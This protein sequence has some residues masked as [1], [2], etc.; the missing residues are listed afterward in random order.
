MTKQDNEYGNYDVITGNFSNMRRHAECKQ[1]RQALASLGLI[2]VG[3][4]EDAPSLSAFEQVARGRMKGPS[5][6]RHGEAGVGGRKKVTHMVQCLGDAVFDLDRRFVATAETIA[7][8]TDVRQLKLLVRFRA[9]NM[10]LEWRKGI[11]GIADLERTTSTALAAALQKMLKDFCQQDEELYN[12]V[13]KHIEVLDADGASDEQ[14]SAREIRAML[15]KDVKMI[16][17]DKAHA[18]RRV[19]SRPWNVM[20]EL[21]EAWS[22]FVGDSSSVVRMIQKSGV[23]SVKFHEHCQAIESVPV[24]AKRIRNLAFKKQ[25]FDSV[26]KPLGRGILFLEA[27]L[28][29]AIWA[30]IH[31]R[32]EEDG[33]NASAFLTWIDEKRII[34]LGMCA[35]CADAAMGLVRSF[36][37]ENHDPAALH[38]QAE[39]FLSELH[40]LFNQEAALRAEG[41][42]QHVLLQLK[43]TRGFLLKGEAKSI[44]GPGKVND[45]ML[46]ECLASMRS[47]VSLAVEVVNSEFPCYE[48]LGAFKLFDVQQRAQGL[49]LELDADTVK[50]HGTRLCQVFGLNIDSFL[51]QYWDHLPIAINE[52]RAHKLENHAAWSSAIRKTSSRSSISQHHPSDTLRLVTMRYLRFHGCSTSGVEQNFSKLQNQITPA[53]DH[54]DP[55][56]YLAEA[57]LVIDCSESDLKE[58]CK[59]AQDSWRKW[60]GAPRESCWNRLDSGVP[61]K[62]QADSEATWFSKRRQHVAENAAMVS[63][64]AVKA[65]SASHEQVDR[66][67]EEKENIDKELAFQRSKQMK[68]QMEA[69]LDR[70]LL[71]REVPPGLRDQV[72][73]ACHKFYLEDTHW[74][75]S[76]GFPQTL[77][78][79]PDPWRADVCVVADPANPPP[80]VLWHTALKG[81]HVVTLSYCIQ[82]SCQGLAY[83]YGAAILTKRSIFVDDRMAAESPEEAEAVRR[84]SRLPQSKWRL[85][86]SWEEFASA[87]DKVAGV[88]LPVKQRREMEVLALT[89]ETVV[90]HLNRRNVVTKEQFLK[91]TV[92]LSCTQRGICGK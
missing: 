22:M 32:S 14:T 36:D 17:K 63:R 44:G 69:Y 90:H 78:L 7:L 30:T 9:A 1:H 86:S 87:T 83:T 23:L 56:T 11:L 10:K 89:V 6:L 79:V 20:P 47:Y 54:M 19:L 25:R 18:S 5:A 43:Q 46:R 82:R 31:R 40:Y 49:A 35:D 27:V 41:Y 52:A 37:S 61:R 28:Q 91:G 48:L 55:A 64:E 62:R 39:R 84:M 57:K 75:H 24:S 26:S 51:T 38:F 15:L 33:K 58:V 34:L 50:E 73:F 68:N 59:A 74:R 60:F 67:E 4:E 66:T 77:T 12:S 3:A 71:E 88:H 21:S 42:T 76:P 92:R 13:L 53:R 81:G 8:H 72:D 85:L 29:T 65:A 16:L 2:D 70:V 80:N 45:A